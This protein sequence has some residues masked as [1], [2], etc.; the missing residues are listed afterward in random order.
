MKDKILI[1]GAGTVGTRDADVLLSLGIPV[2]LC[3]YDAAEDDIKTFELKN[4]MHINRHKR[5]L[6]EIRAARGSNIEERIKHLNH[7]FGACA[8]SIDDTDFSRIALAIDCT[9]KVEGRNYDEI[10]NKH[11]L[12]F[13]LNGGAEGKFVKNRHFASV[14]NSIVQEKLDEYRTQ[15]SKIVSCNTHALTT[16]IGILKGVLGKGEEFRKHFRDP[17]MVDFL[18]RH[19]DPNKGKK[20]SRYVT[21]EHKRYHTEEVEDLHPELRNW[22]TNEEELDPKLYS[23]GLE[24][25]V[26]SKSK[27]PTEYFHTLLV[28]FDFKEPIS[29]SLL[30]DIRLKIHSYPRAILS[31]KDISHE[32]TIKAA[33]WA[34][35]EDGDIPFPVY[36][37]ERFGRH[38]LRVYGLTPQRGIVAPSTADYT[39]LRTGIVPGINSWE[40]AFNYVNKNAKYRN[41]TFLHI[42][43]SIQYNLRNYEAMNDSINSGK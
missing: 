36:M 18:R 35:I 14:P 33:E 31:E 24:G 34:R 20:A 4:V 19:E 15:D 41:E 22:F 29:N 5:E 17:I 43:N 38:H 10:Y 3:K 39:L 6:I 30:E 28:T 21:L 1:M 26:S 25:L 13:A 32:K 12:A 2:T 42:K 11:S 8:G 9:D 40:D 16:L 27:W 37:V 7:H 23:T